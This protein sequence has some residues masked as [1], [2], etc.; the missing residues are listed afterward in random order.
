M[1]SLDNAT[2]QDLPQAVGVLINTSLNPKGMPIA[3]EALD[4]LAMFCA[5]TGDELDFVLLEET[6]LL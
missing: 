1:R 5:P 6:W 3:A 4:V 2:S